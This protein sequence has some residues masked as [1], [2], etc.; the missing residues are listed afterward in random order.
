MNIYTYKY[1]D[2]LAGTGT[3]VAGLGTTF[4]EDAPKGKN[5]EQL[6]YV[7]KV[8]LSL[9]L[10]LREACI[11][12]ASELNHQLNS[13]LSSTDIEHWSDRGPQ[14]P[15]SMPGSDRVGSYGSGRGSRPDPTFSGFGKSSNRNNNSDISVLQGQS[16][17]GI[18][19]YTYEYI[20]IHI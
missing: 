10:F 7:E 6:S 2:G 1:T 9:V 11:A 3:F 20:Y 5:M 13:I 18:Y 8:A 17:P 14:G 19:M 12:A 4:K 15:G 16:T